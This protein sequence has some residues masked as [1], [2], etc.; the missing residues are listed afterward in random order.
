METKRHYNKMKSKHKDIKCIFFP[1]KKW[2]YLSNM[3]MNGMYG[4]FKIF[5]LLM[6]NGPQSNG[7]K[8]FR[9]FKRFTHRRIPV[10]VSMNSSMT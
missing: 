8:A 3:I 2:D 9:R 6:L 10:P 4:D 1:K 7:F 5:K